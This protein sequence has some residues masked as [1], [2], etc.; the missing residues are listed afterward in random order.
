MIIWFTGKKFNEDSGNPVPCLA[1][2]PAIF[3]Y[4]QKNERVFK[5]DIETTE[6]IL[7]NFLERYEG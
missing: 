3:P 4:H 7:I 6:M 5:K 1:L 2:E